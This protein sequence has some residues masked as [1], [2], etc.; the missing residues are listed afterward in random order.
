[1]TPA[2][3]DHPIH[4][5]EILLAEFLTPYGLSRGRVGRGT[6]LSAGR[7]ARL[8]QGRGRITAEM[9]LLLVRAFR[10]TPRFW[11]NLQTHYDLT[12]AQATI[13]PARVAGARALGRRL[14]RAR[15]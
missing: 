1:M 12:Q 10:T 14:Q 6:G 13:A 8:M 2:T 3:S 7:L 15:R 5:G 9:A 11:L 4:P